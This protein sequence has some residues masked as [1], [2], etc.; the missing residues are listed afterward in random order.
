MGAERDLN[1]ATQAPPAILQTK[2]IDKSGASDATPGQ[3]SRLMFACMQSGGRLLKALTFT[4]SVAR[5]PV[6]ASHL[7]DYMFRTREIQAV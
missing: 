3:S 2:T 4:A 6:A 1:H 5:L 7:R